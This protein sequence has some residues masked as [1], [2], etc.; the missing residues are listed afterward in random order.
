MLLPAGNQAVAVQCPGRWYVQ[1]LWLRLA[2]PGGRALPSMMN[3]DAPPCGA[4]CVSGR[5]EPVMLLCIVNIC[6]V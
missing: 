2:L 1:R 6:G 5:R 4:R 3:Q